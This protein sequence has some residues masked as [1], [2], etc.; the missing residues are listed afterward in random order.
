MITFV[1]TTKVYTAKIVI[2]L[3]RM[4]Y[5][6]KIISYLFE[7]IIIL[8]KFFKEL[9]NVKEFNYFNEL[10]ILKYLSYFLNLC[11]MSVRGSSFKYWLFIKCNTFNWFWYPK[12]ADQQ[13]VDISS[14]IWTNFLNKN[15]FS[16]TKPF[17]IDALTTTPFYCY[18]FTTINKYC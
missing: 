15:K 14:L 13:K 12:V 3:N 7:I 16:Q 11:C 4:R 5:N 6:F 8:K 10:I 1:F 17:S 9:C 2:I 18:L